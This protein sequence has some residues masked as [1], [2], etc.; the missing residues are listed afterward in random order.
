MPRC[1]FGMAF[2]CRDGG[3]AVT[4]IGESLVCQCGINGFSTRT[5]NVE[6]WNRQFAAAWEI[7]RPVN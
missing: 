1:R 2:G 5:G 7:G 6:A 4:M 3:L